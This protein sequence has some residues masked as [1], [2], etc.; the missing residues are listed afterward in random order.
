M[1]TDLLRKKVLW[2]DQKEPLLTNNS[3]QINNTAYI[4]WPIFEIAAF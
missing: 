1:L 4:N 2:T 3:D